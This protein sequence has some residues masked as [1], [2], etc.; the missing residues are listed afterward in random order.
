[1]RSNPRHLITILILIIFSA[2]TGNHS[3]GEEPGVIPTIKSEFPTVSNATEFKSDWWNACVFYEIFVRSFKDSDGDGIGDFN[4]II[5]MLDYLNDGDLTTDDD[6]GITG[7]WLM[8]VTESPSY[9]GYDVVDY[10]GVDPEYGTKE[11]FLRLIEEAHKRGIKVIVDLVI[12]HTSIENPWFIASRAGD[13]LYRDWYVWDTGN[14]TFLGPWGEQV[15]FQGGDGYYYAVFSSGMPDLNLKN[16]VVTDEIYKIT[17]FWINE[18]KVDGFR[19]DAIRHFVESGRIQENT[20]ETHL[21][22]QVFHDYYKSIDP[23]LFSIG[24]AWTDTRHVIEYIGDEVDI[25]FEFDLAES[26]MLA[27]RGPLVSS[28]SRQIQITL[29]NY[30]ENQYGVFLTNHD[31]N[32]VMSVLDGDLDRAKLAAV[33]LLTS[34]GVPF[35]YY[36]EEIGMTGIKP[37]ENIRLPMQ[38]RGDISSAGFST[39]IPW[40]PVQND[41]QETNVSIESNDSDSLLYLYRMLVHLRNDHPSLREGKSLILS[42]GTKRLYSILRYNETEAFLIL[43]NVHTKNITSDLYSL[44]TD[45]WPI[46]EEFKMT[47][48]HGPGDPALPNP[49]ETDSLDGY[50]PFS[51]IPAESYA[52]LYF[53]R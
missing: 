43:V 5:E 23:V 41:Y 46:H 7:I 16:A 26:Y 44:S 25:A 48:V 15:W 14:P 47:M 13:P 4:G 12:N 52:I 22:L 32:R 17:S 36:G 31:Q 3:L 38:W 10:Y 6:L 9:H 50:I 19:L 21:W 53:Y 39:S 2:C 1:M 40:R 28:L 45:A 51:D 49:S 30:P 35:I 8:P 29:E 33:F 34:P 18:M 27:A 11:D 37:D 24:E 20:P 42:T